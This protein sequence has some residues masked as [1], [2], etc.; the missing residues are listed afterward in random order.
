MTTMTVSWDSSSFG[1]MI[2]LGSL[3]RC[4][5]RPLGIIVRRFFSLLTISLNAIMHGLP[6]AHMGWGMPPSYLLVRT[7]TRSG[8]GPAI[9]F[10]PKPSNRNHDLAPQV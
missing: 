3:V 1:P 8:A 7:A 10:L 6:A 9:D 5:L 2:S 4:Q